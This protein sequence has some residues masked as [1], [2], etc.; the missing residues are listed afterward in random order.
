MIITLK[1]TGGFIGIEQ[2]LGSVDLAGLD[3]DQRQEVMVRLQTLSDL[4]ATIPAPGADQLQYEI[5]I[6]E[7]GRSPRSLTVLD[8]SPPQQARTLAEL[9]SSL[10]LS[11]V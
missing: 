11:A 7:S 2:D 1:R 10:G 6:V 4:V 5:G 8:E 3:K 9:L